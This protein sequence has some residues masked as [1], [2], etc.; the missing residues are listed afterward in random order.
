MKKI[1]RIKGTYVYFVAAIAIYTALSQCNLYTPE[2]DNPLDLKGKNPP[3]TITLL[4]IPGVAVPVLGATPV[5]T[6]IDT[7]QYT[8]TISWSPSDSTF[9]ATT[10]YTATI[11]LKPKIGYIL[12]GMAANSLTVAGATAA[13]AANSGIVTAVFPATL[14]R[15]SMVNVPAGS[16]QADGIATNVYTITTSY[17]MS[18][19]EITRSQFSALFNTDPSAVANSSGATDPVQRTHWYDAIAF[20][21]KMSIA[22]GL[23]PVYSV[24]VAGTPVNWNTLTYAEIPA[25]N[26]DWD[27]VTATWTNNGYRLPTEMEWM[28]A[29]MGATSDR[30][31]GYTGNGVNTTG[32]PKGYA[33]S[34]EVGE[35]QVNIGNYAWYNANSSNK[36]HPVGTAGTSG[37][38]NELGL[39][40]MSGN[41]VEWCW[42]WGDIYPGTA[43][44]DYRGPST[45]VRRVTRG[46]SWYGNTYSC[47][48]RM[49]GD[50]G[51]G[52]RHYSIG[53]RVVRY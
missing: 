4:A 7:A 38:P 6:V 48:I 11:N 29:A 49:R 50:S 5:T 24:T 12:T 28:W 43:Q 35:A 22:E 31:N 1:V 30:S 53:F 41:V 52:N 42:D 32:F 13:H 14:F 9:S 26:P 36:T 2:F 21:N 18:A 27:G 17:K 33:G 20:C 19:Y 3:K 40:D 10:A 37:H 34:T 51:P 45:G 39:Y 15:L 46:G 8:G 25:N 47:F 23:T 44:T 16:F